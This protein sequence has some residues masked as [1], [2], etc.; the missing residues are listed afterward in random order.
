MSDFT[1]DIHYL[2]F[3]ELVADICIQ[4]QRAPAHFYTVESRSSGPVS[5]LSVSKTSAPPLRL[6]AS[7]EGG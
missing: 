5:I 6:S 1:T 2:A 7:V 4:Q 3:C